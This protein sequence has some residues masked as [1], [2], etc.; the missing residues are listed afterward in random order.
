MERVGDTKGETVDVRVIAATNCNLRKKVEQGE[1]RDDL[2][3]RL[4][5]VE[6]PIPPLRE[7]K[8]DLP[9]LVEHFR[10][11][12]KQSLK[13]EIWEISEEARQILQRYNWPGNIRELRHAIEHACIRCHTG[14]ITPHHLPPELS[15]DTTEKAVSKNDKLLPT[16]LVYALQKTG[17]NKSKAASYLGI[18]R[19]TLYRKLK[20]HGISVK[21]M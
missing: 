5:V 17:G 13:K 8:E 11:I 10:I 7:R 2:Y 14:V 6:V 16:H 18:S 15:Q 4:K 20:E 1:F 19:P 9:L 12:F 21:D 3:Y